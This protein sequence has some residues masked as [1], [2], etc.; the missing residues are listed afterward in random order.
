MNALSVLFLSIPLA[1]LVTINTLIASFHQ[2]RYLEDLPQIFEVSSGQTG[3]TRDLVLT[4]LGMRAL[5][6]DLAFLDVLVYYG[7]R[8]NEADAHE[9]EHAS[10]WGSD[11]RM[12][13]DLYALG[14]RIVGLDPFFR[15]AILYA[16]N[17]LAFNEGR[18]AQAISLL[19]EAMVKDG[20]Y[21][22]YALNLS[23]I[24]YKDTGE[25]ARLIEPIEEMRSYP[26]CPDMLKN[27]LGNI[28]I[29]TGR[30]AEALGVFSEIA[31]S[32][33]DE[34]YRKLAQEKVGY[35]RGLRRERPH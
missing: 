16:A 31:A 35:L 5:A 18:N 17:S 3:G 8:P 22:P 13:V 1:A 14:R 30:F 21:W 4:S 25:F 33:K 2:D 7:S 34:E 24:A 9:W 32:G 6:S 20:G 29:K 15:S 19:K 23:A 12:Y 28:Y 26:E 11:T 10:G 27:I